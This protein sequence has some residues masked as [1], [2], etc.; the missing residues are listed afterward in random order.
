MLAPVQGAVCPDPND[1]LYMTSYCPGQPS[2][3]DT[4]LSGEFEL[5]DL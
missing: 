5:R 4:A 3:V 1:F 2:A